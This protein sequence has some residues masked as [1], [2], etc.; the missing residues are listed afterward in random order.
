MSLHD[1]CMQCVGGQVEGRSSQEEGVTET[2]KT[3][4]R[5]GEG[6]N[7]SCVVKCLARHRT[8]C[9]APTPADPHIS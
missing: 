3:E 1:E 7:A 5:L 4:G 9:L 2:C 8:C 6:R